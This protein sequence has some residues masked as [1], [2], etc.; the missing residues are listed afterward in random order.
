MST[1]RATRRVP[2]P[3][4]SLHVEIH[5]HGSPVLCWPSLYCDAR[6]LDPLIDDLAG[7]HEVIVV[8]GPGHGGSD[9]GPA[10][11]SLATCAD[12]AIAVLDALGA[13]RATWVGAAWGGHIGAAVAHRHPHRLTGLVILNAPMA[14]WSG[15]RWVMMRAA[16]ALLWLFGPRSFVATMIADAM[17]ARS[18]GPDRAAMVEA[19][20]A[21]VHRCDRRGLLVAA[22]SAMFERGDLRPLLPQV[23]VPTLF[24][25]GAEDTLFPVEEARSQASLLPDCRFVVVEHSSHQSVLEAPRSVLPALRAALCAWSLSDPPGD[26][27]IRSE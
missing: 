11:F 18:A 8:D 5:G 26:V 17:I 10:S 14:P 6:T 24:F 7:D 1:L 19:I 20:A 2:T 27:R 22:R 12:A 23:R 15:R 4:G 9:P 16:Y 21:A 3:I 25:S 13:G